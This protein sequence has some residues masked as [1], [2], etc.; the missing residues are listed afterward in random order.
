[1]RLDLL[2]QEGAG[3]ENSSCTLGSYPTNKE[4][5]QK[6]NF[7]KEGVKQ[8]KRRHSSTNV[9]CYGKQATVGRCQQVLGTKTLV[10]EI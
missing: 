1:M 5:S 3:K 6:W 4:I 10:L 9:Q 7:S 8:L 2:Y